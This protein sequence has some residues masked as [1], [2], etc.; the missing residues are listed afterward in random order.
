MTEPWLT[1]AHTLGSLSGCLL[2][3]ALL[4]RSVNRMTR[5]HAVKMEARDYFKGLEALDGSK[6]ELVE[7]AWAI[8]S[9]AGNGDW[10]K[11]TAVWQEVAAKWRDSY[12]AWLD[13]RKEMG[14]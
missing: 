11:E 5:N 8:I 1:V 12:H 10:G 6:T 2:A 3:T 9:N 4:Q 14:L 13:A 7:W